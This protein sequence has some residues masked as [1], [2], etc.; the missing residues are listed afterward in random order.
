MDENTVLEA[1]QQHFKFATFKSQLQQNAV[2]EIVKGEND[3]LVSMPT[4]SGKSLCYQLPAVLKPNKITIVFSPLL[5][6]IKDQID[7]MLALK[8]RA[9]SLNS[10]TLKAERE[11][12]LMDL[13]TTTP[14]TRLLYITP[15]QAATNTFKELFKNLTKFN[16][17]AYLVVDEAHCVSQWGHDFRPD[18]LKL[19][20]L[21]NDNKIP[22]IALTATAGVEVTKD[23][24]NSLKLS[25]DHRKFKTSSFRSNLYYDVFYQN[26]V[27]DM[28]KHLKD[29]I[30]ECLNSEEEKE[31]PK[32]ERSCGIVYCRTREQTE[33]IA[34]KLNSM[35]IRS[36]CYHA[37]LKNKERLD[38]QEQWQSGDYPVICAT[39]SFGMGVDKSSVRFVI[40]WGIPKDPASYYQE[41]GRAGRDGKPSKCR[42]Y[43]NKADKK[44]VE[45][46]LTRDLGKAQDNV[47]KK[48]NA[49]SA[50]NGFAKIVQ[51]CETVLEC[52]HKLFSKYFGDPPPNCMKNCDICTNRKVV[53]DMVELFHTKNIQFSTTQENVDFEDMYGGG[54]KGQN[55]EL[56]NYGN[57][58]ES[59]GER[60]S[61]AKKQTDEFI[62]KQFAIRKNPKEAS[63]NTMDKLLQ[64]NARVLSA[65]STGSKVKGLSLVNREQYLTKIT[66]TLYDNYIQ[67][68]TN[69]L[70]DRKDVEDCS[71][72]LEYGVFSTTTNITMYRSALAKLIAFIKKCTTDGQIH[73]ALATHEVQ[74]AKNETLSDLFRNIKK[75]QTIRKRKQDNQEP[76]DNKKL[77]TCFV[78]ASELIQM[79]VEPPEDE[80]ENTITNYFK[81]T[82]INKFSELIDSEHKSDLQKHEEIVPENNKSNELEVTKSDESNVSSVDKDVML[83]VR[84]EESVS[85]IEDL[86][87]KTEDAL[88]SKSNNNCHVK[89]K[90][91]VV[92]VSKPQ[93]V[94]K[95][96]E[97]PKVEGQSTSTKDI[98]SKVKKL[99]GADSDNEQSDTNKYTPNKID[100]KDKSKKLNKVNAGVLVVKLLN[101]AFSEGRFESK[102]TFKSIS[103]AITHAFIGKDVNDIKMYV[104]NFLE[105]NQV[106]TSKT[107]V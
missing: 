46:H 95:P 2:M 35:G 98:N 19:G 37:G 75:D 51:Y 55:D 34:E 67:C 77:K 45:F 71:A 97:K 90:P 102:E 91:K 24:V 28:Y 76:E 23:I 30:L 68:A 89:S 36:Q 33:I 93:P 6:L 78:K 74:P 16:K 11:A 48:L 61:K 104:R 53:A 85:R 73:E 94:P 21:R 54:R 15:E 83:K 49:Q 103:R 59:D 88:R 92:P 57:E 50:M 13:K 39:I 22:V 87:R 5:A 64:K 27:D 99:F 25:I 101:P 84:E 38:F 62:K 12:L 96:S 17:V 47:S 107:E 106:I 58:C 70:F 100:D 18:Y 32:E 56:E 80:G 65:A 26:I 29:F 40:H 60:E 41:S 14:N 1:L 8:I 44:A 81:K 4:G 10:K 20:E 52:R 82:N 86:E 69:P 42:I 79:E 7:H 3:V 105:K 9:A 63:H 72:N 43:Y 31:L 66:D